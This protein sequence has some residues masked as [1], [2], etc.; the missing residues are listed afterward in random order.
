MK[1][2]VLCVTRD[3]LDIQDGT[4]IIPK[5]IS[6]IPEDSYH[7]INRAV[8]DSE[9]YD[10]IGY[11]LPQIL[12]YVIIKCGNQVLTY[13]RKGGEGRLHGLRSLGIGGHVD[14]DDFD[15]TAAN[16]YLNALRVSIEREVWEEVK[17]PARIGTTQLDSL[18]VDTSNSV[19]KVH[20]G[21]P[22]ILE[23]ESTHS[24]N[25]DPSEILDPRWVDIES[26]QY[27]RHEYENWSQLIIDLLSASSNLH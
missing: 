18:I 20:L 6:D 21:V 19:G 2:A 14:I 8:C 9:D 12:G 27:D 26:L 11:A 23:V 16:P 17:Y 22:V 25:A 7:F 15:I 1:P 5:C 3:V 13:A 10:K 24:L 4:Y